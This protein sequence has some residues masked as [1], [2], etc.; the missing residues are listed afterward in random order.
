MAT[1]DP[2]VCRQLT[3]TKW[4]N[5]YLVLLSDPTLA[6]TDA[7]THK[8]WTFRLE[9]MGGK[10][11]AVTYW[12][13]K[14]IASHEYVYEGAVTEDTLQ[15]IHGCMLQRAVSVGGRGLED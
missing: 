5:A 14:R 2:V 15:Q 7:S 11:Y 6:S 12:G 8:D 3:D 13:I 4:A 10:V 9:R 1:I